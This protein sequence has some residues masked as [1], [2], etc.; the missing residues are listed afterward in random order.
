VYLGKKLELKVTY[1][2]EDLTSLYRVDRTGNATTEMH[3]RTLLKACT[4]L[5]T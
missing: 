4:W 1:D 5:T 2:L 3:A